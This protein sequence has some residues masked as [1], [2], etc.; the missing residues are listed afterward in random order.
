[1]DFTSERIALW[2]QVLQPEKQPL[3]D[4][5]AATDAAD[6]AGITRLR[7]RWDAELISVAYELLRARSKA[8][9]KFP[10]PDRLAADVQGV[11][12]AT[13]HIVARHKA[14][15]FAETSDATGGGRIWD[16]CCG[17][18]GDSMAL[19]AIAEV[20]AVDQHPLRAW[21]AG[22]N[23]GCETVAADV[24]TLTIRGE[25]F[26]LDPDRRAPGWIGGESQRLW[27]YED[28][29]PGPAFIDHLLT[30]CPNGA[31]KLGP[32]VDLDSLPPGPDREIE[33]ISFNNTLVQAVL[34]CGALATNPGLRTA[35]R[36]PEG[37][38]F[39]GTPGAPGGPGGRPPDIAECVERYL[40]VMHKAVERS[41]LIDALCADLPVREIHPGLGLFTSEEPICSP[42]LSSFEVVAEM[43][44]RIK[45]IRAWLAAN[46]AGVVEVKTRGGAVETDTA[47][48]KLR[49]G[50]DTRFTIFGLRLGRKI[51]AV[52]TRRLPAPE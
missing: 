37:L 30:D 48:K 26:H 27:R 40:L 35:T 44:W 7:S 15:R 1:M 22:R 17:I 33:I 31:I 32:G 39:T 6:V 24:K 52:I 25:R 28:Y 43:P 16:L 50:G 10:E 51:I 49:C 8:E 3:L 34:W 13:S 18:G 21:M 38:S 45:K 29:N 46:D 2:R 47:Q 19:A 14:R 9:K 36:L 20:T 42:W 23:A 11:E 41:Q 4:A 12:Q 5:A